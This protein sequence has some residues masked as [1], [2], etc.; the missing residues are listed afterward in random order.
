[1]NAADGVPRLLPYQA[2][3]GH[4]AAMKILK[5]TSRTISTKF[6]PR[7]LPS[8]A[9]WPQGGKRRWRESTQGNEAACNLTVTG[10]GDADF[11]GI[12]PV[13]WFG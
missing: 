9:R 7:K 11:E 12:A 1:M 3:V 8:R 13:L 6:L 4:L 5:A 10:E 2:S